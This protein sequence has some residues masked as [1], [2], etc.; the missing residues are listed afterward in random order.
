MKFYHE[1]VGE[2]VNQVYEIEAK[3]WEEAKKIVFNRMA[4]GD[5]L[6]MCDDS[7]VKEYDKWPDYHYIEEDMCKEFARLG[8]GCWANYTNSDVDY[9]EDR[10]YIFSNES[11]TY[12]DSNGDIFEDWKLEGCEI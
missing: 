10:V 6:A 11:D 4:V 8:R 3:T 2:C 5:H 9:W 7:A 12:L 1:S